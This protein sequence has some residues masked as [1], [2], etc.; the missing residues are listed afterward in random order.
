MSR[1]HTEQA[2]TLIEALIALALAAFVVAAAVSLY[3]AQRGA[4]GTSFD[5]LRAR[6]AASTALAL[7]A[8]SVHMAGFVPLDAPADASMP[9]FGCT[10]AWPS[11]DPA[12][13]GCAAAANSDGLQVRYI[14]DAVS[15]WPTA[16][17]QVTDC[18]GQGVG[19][20]AERPS[21][22]NRYFV[23]NR[24][25]STEPELYCEGSGR[26]GVAQPL[27]EGIERLRMRYRLRDEA[28]W[29]DAGA[30]AGSAWANVAAVE[31]C[32]EARGAR[33]ARASRYVDCDGRAHEVRN[34]RARWIAR[35]WLSLRNGM[36]VEGAMR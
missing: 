14:G 7:I 21:V 17:G 22:V 20:Q 8:Q 5:G 31:I 23:R 29:R 33:A 19:T 34:D 35:Q 24:S 30:I 11:G 27:V 36:A 16:N 12:R 25:G 26:P 28:I 13:P 3:R 18:L 10:S 4:H 32:V 2:H 1:R 6:D 9:L 15:T